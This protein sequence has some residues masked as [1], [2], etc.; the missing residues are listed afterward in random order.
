MPFSSGQQYTTANRYSYEEQFNLV[1]VGVNNLI[2]SSSLSNFHNQN[3]LAPVQIYKVSCAAGSSVGNGSCTTCPL[4]YFSTTSNAESC[5]QCPYS[6]M[7]TPSTGTTDGSQCFNPTSSF[8]L[9]I[10]SF[11]IAPFLVLVYFMQCRV[12]FVSFIRVQFVI[13]RLQ[14]TMRL[15]SNYIKEIGSSLYLQHSF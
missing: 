11:M 7:T 14:I 3:T 9:A 5:S 10:V 8:L 12:H 2:I 4:K 13:K 15:F 1:N 6:A